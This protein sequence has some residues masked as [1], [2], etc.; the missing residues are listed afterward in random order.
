MKR[1]PAG[2]N[3]K[4]VEKFLQEVGEASA[5]Q[6]KRAA[7]VRGNIYQTMSKMESLGL[8][9]KIGKKY[10]VSGGGETKPIQQTQQ[11]SFTPPPHPNASKIDVLIDEID[12]VRAGIQTLEAT[13]NYL[14]RRVQQLTE[15]RF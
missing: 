5:I 11:S 12:H 15:Q 8:V 6:I 10:S 9:K 3:H 13:L 14:E 4:A 1:K 2:S 7:K